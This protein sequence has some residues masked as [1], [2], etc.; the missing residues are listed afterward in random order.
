[1]HENTFPFLRPFFLHIW[2]AIF[3]HKR[4]ASTL[5][6]RWHLLKLNGSPLTAPTSTNSASIPSLQPQRLTPT[7]V[8]FP[9]VR[10]HACRWCQEPPPVLSCSVFLCL[11][12]SS[13]CICTHSCSLLH[14]S[15]C[16]PLSF[17]CVLFSAVFDKSVF[18]FKS[19]DLSDKFFLM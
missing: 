12:Q 14:L 3:C 11:S 5:P 1:M 7:I 13:L 6:C 17:C 15:I 9:A 18:I 16:V 4:G 10:G 19:F 2:V 8:R